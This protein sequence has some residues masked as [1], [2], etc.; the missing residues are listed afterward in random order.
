M[1]TTCFP[2]FRL[3]TVGIKHKKI[4]DL[5]VSIDLFVILKWEINVKII[6]SCL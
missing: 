1:P 6:V 3:I 5:C 4:K 2:L